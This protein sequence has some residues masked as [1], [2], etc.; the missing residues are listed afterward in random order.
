MSAFKNTVLA[1]ALGFLPAV[2]VASIMGDPFL[3]P[4]AAWAISSFIIAIKLQEDSEVSAREKQRVK[5][6][7]AI[8]QN[9]DEYVTQFIRKAKI[10]SFNP[11]QTRDDVIAVLMESGYSKMTASSIYNS[12][13]V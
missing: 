10:E 7:T 2:L 13:K 9:E 12:V 5:H 3:T 6:I 4:F 8:E 1:I 11:E